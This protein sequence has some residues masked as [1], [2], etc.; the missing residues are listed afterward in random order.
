L[1]QMI[2]EA[3]ALQA[4]MVR[5]RRYLHENAEIGDQLPNTASYVT[6]RLQ[7]LGYQPNEI[8]RC[9]ISAIVGR[10]TGRSFLLRA[11]MDALPIC[12]ETALP[13]RSRTGH[14]HA[15]GHDLHTAMLLGAAELLMRHKD[16]LNGQVK[17]MFQPAEETMAGAAA[18][19][20]AGVLE[21]PQVD[22]AFM[23][24]VISGIPAPTNTII[25]PPA[26]A[27]SAGS[28]WFTIT[29]QGQGGHGAAPDKTLDPLNALSHIY[30]SLQSINAREVASGDGITLTVGQISGGS[31]ANVIPDKG[32][33]AG[34]I[35]TFGQETRE[36]VKMRLQQIAEG[37]ASTF[38]VTASVHFEKSCP[39]VYIDPALRDQVADSAARLFG[40]DRLAS[41]ERIMH[42]SRLPA[43][44]DFAFI[45]ERVPSMMAM[46]V[47]GSA[48]EGYPFPPHHPK[49][50]FDE[51]ALSTGAA[52]YADTAIQWLRRDK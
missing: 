45:S 40:P 44:E 49:T 6:T 21:N 11:D 9:G 37:I 36:F 18:M 2:R 32:F 1:A 30:L 13:F 33:L 24:H 5:D 22:A 10:E 46:L 4:S 41:M 19:I 20:S 47:A 25:L 28:D 48:M 15:C 16:E 3:Q 52:L 42:A 39:S 29:V 12:E 51:E 14:M 27:V 50:V 35:R 23:I 43:A 7:E 34:T 8:S 31:T 17:L 26:G 38:R